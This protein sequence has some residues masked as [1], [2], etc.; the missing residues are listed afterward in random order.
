MDLSG[1][2]LQYVDL[3]GADLRGANLAGA[4]LPSDLSGAILS[5]EGT[6]DLSQ[7]LTRKELWE[8]I[9]YEFGLKGFLTLTKQQ[10]EI[11]FEIS[12]LDALNFNRLDEPIN[13]K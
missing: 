2:D 3:R 6:R 13:P 1:R 9:G 12:Q 11:L 7:H 10:Q 4:R 5:G 8:K